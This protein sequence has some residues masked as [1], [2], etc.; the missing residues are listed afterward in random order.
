MKAQ[1]AT[2]SHVR[3]YLAGMHTRPE[4][5]KKRFALAVSGSA[6]L[7]IFTLWTLARFGAGGTPDTVAQTPVSDTSSSALSPVAS[8]KASAVDAWSTITGQIDKAKQ[9]LQSVDLQNSYTEVRNDA[10]NN[11]QN[12]TTYGQ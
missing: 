2:D 7:L 9:G 5:H 3:K 4:H 1:R 12:S 6:T 8:L 10:L 11:Q